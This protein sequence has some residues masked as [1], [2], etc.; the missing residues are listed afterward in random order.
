MHGDTE[1]NYKENELISYFFFV[2][3]YLVQKMHND[4]FDPTLLLVSHG[5]E[6]NPEK[7][8]NIFFISI[9]IRTNFQAIHTSQVE[10]KLYLK[11]IF[12]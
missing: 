11:L 2:I 4:F 12:I 5:M 3:F 9:N 1:N 6:S 7:L 8:C 10:S